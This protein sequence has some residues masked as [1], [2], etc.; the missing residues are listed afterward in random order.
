[1]TPA[2]TPAAL[3]QAIRDAGARPFMV[4]PGGTVTHAALAD[5]IAGVTALFQARGLRPGDRVVILTADE[6][7]A[8]AAFGAAL[9]AGLVPTLPAA[10]SAPDRI[11][12]ICAQLE[13]ALLL[14]PDAADAGGWAGPRAA[15]PAPRR[16]GSVLG[17]LLSRPPRPAPEVVPAA[18]GGDD[19]AYVLFT[20]GT[21]AAPSGVQITW[22]NLSAHLATLVRLFGFGPGSRVFN[23]TPIAHTDGLVFGPLLAMATGGTVLRPAPFRVAGIDDWLAG[24]AAMG[25]THVVTNPTVLAL[26]DRY[27]TGDAAFRAPGFRGVICSASVLRPDLWDRLEARFGITLWNLY[28]LTETV[29]SAL[30]AGPHP[31]MGARG[32]IGRAIDCAVRLGDADGT[33]LPDLPGTEGEIQLRGDH[34]FAGYWRNPDR[35]AAT[36]TPDGWM[37]TGDRARLRADGSLDFLGRIKAA[38]NCGGTLVRGEEIDDCLLRHPAVVEAVTVPLPDPDFEEVPVSAVVLSGPATEAD[39]SAHA[40]AGLEALKVPRRIVVVASIPRGPSGKPRLEEVKAL[41]AA[42]PD[43][44]SPPPAGDDVTDAIL[45]IAAEVFR[46][47]PADLTP[48]ASPDSVAAWDSF[49]HLNLILEIERHF[50]LRIPAAQVAAARSLAALVGTVRAL[51]P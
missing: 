7:E 4:T 39:L 29:T 6:A 40:R 26:V 41:L 22:T 33:P 49:T 28:G 10:D 18:R 3:W 23:P 24:I 42:Q 30:Y 44:A 2:A 13:A 5:R 46:L 45:T 14:A 16:A 15:P 19:T 20:S 48:E 35:T 47:D 8:A 38:I 43:R 27:A 11:G 36:F 1:M 31:E 25:A 21:T 51:R 34:I 9:V 12:A 50:G 17:R 37:R 32:S